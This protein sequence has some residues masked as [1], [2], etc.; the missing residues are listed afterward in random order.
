MHF[1]HRVVRSPGSKI[2]G[3]VITENLRS[4]KINFQWF[5]KFQPPRPI[6]KVFFPTFIHHCDISKMVVENKAVC[7]YGLKATVKVDSLGP[8]RFR[9]SEGWDSMR[10]FFP[11][12]FWPKWTWEFPDI[13]ANFWPQILRQISSTCGSVKS[14]CLFVWVGFWQRN[15][16]IDVGL[17]SHWEQHSLQEITLVEFT[18]CLRWFRTS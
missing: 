18:F 17:S 11:V 6:L 16:L 14:F 8:F 13:L 9:R 2:G 12:G 5:L 7:N 4:F 1:R 3:L 15:L 10:F